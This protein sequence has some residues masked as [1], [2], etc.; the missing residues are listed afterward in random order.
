MTDRN[1]SP[2]DRLR[3]IASAHQGREEKRRQRLARQSGPPRPGNIYGIPLPVPGPEVW[4]VFQSPAKHATVLVAMDRRPFFSPSDLWTDLA[5]DDVCLRRE[6]Q[7]SVPQTLLTEDR[8]IDHLEGLGEISTKNALDNN[9]GHPVSEADLT[10]E[11]NCWRRAIRGAAGT[12]PDWLSRRRLRLHVDCMQQASALGESN[13]ISE[14][15][16]PTGMSTTSAPT[17]ESTPSHP[18]LKLAASSSS[19][20]QRF[21]AALRSLNSAHYSQEIFCPGGRLR[22][23]ASAR[24]VAFVFEPEAGDDPPAIF[25]GPDGAAESISWVTKPQGNRHS[26]WTH[27]WSDGPCMAR[28]ETAN[29]F[30]L[31][32]ESDDLWT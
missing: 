4:C 8:R 26:M 15:P 13:P 27:N 5:G 25:M 2:S 23:I 22:L 29:P 32:I 6:H 17:M 3:A 31:L 11:E 21:Q 9:D 20:I 16:P 24:G 30:E 28:I 14:S 10:T 1:D 18:P 12:L 19:P 7:I